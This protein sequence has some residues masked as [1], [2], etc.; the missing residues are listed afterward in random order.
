LVLV[1]QEETRRTR[2]AEMAETPCFIASHQRV[3]VAVEDM[4]VWQVLLV[5]RVEAVAWVKP[6]MRQEGLERHRKDLAEE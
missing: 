2:L 3:V 5:G 1:E 4:T 6:P